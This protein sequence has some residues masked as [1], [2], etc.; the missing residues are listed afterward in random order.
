[1]TQEEVVF[2]QTL[3]EALE[4]DN[5]LEILKLLQPSTL[6]ID[7]T[8][9]FNRRK[10]NQ[11]IVYIT[12]KVPTRIKEKVQKYKAILYKYC[13]EIFDETDEYA[14]EDILF[15]IMQTSGMV[16]NKDTNEIASSNQTYVNFLAKLQ[17]VQIDEIEKEYLHEACNCAINGLR[18]AAIT[19]I[20]CAAERL[21]IQLCNSYLSYLKENGTL[22][23]IANFERDAI[24]AKKASSRL[25]CFQ[26]T[27]SNKETL[28]RSFGLENSNLHFGFLDLLRQSRNDSGHPTGKRISEVDQNTYFCNYQLLL[29]K[30]HPVLGKLNSKC[31]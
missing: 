7:R 23:E 12:I 5:H 22:N 24:N 29:D 28:F 25:D 14:L 30:I 31:K 18:L 19:M 11:C 3:K 9:T 13:A 1:M 6:N 21:L 2:I 8:G 27:V 4:G 26:K 10:W 20:G 16:I 15:G 17:Q